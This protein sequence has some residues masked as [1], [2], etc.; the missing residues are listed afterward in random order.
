MSKKLLLISSRHDDQLFAESCA[1]TAGLELI[2]EPHARNAAQLLAKSDVASVFADAPDSGT[3]REVE[4][5]IAESVGLYSDKISGNTMHWIGTPELTEVSFLYQSPIFGNII[6]RNYQDPAVAGRRYG[7]VLRAAQTDKAFGLANIL[8]PGTKVQV[9]RFNLSTQKQEGVEAV[10]N[11]LL[12]IK[13]KTRMAVVIA[14]AVDELLM[15]AIFDAPVD[16]AGKPVYAQTTRDTELELRGKH[17]VELH[18]GY[19]G[20]YIAITA[21]DLFGS[22]DKAKLFTHISKRYAEEEY[23][24]RASYAGA[25][26]GLATVFRS[27][28]SFLF[29]SEGG[30]KTEVTVFFKRTDN[31]R[32]FKDQFRF[33]STQFYF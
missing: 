23:K 14:N 30:V 6:C 19:D 1:L 8:P 27:G 26:I 7:I 29:V 18:V 16:A 5:A 2:I 31:F 4:Q 9:I 25:G 32:D 15:N 28:G 21:V 13:F 3:A 24:V 17:Q 11:F 33:I 20:E 12:A 10:K 22:L